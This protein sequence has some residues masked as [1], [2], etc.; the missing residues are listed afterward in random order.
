VRNRS[1]FLKLP[2]AAVV[3]AVA[4]IA[5]AALPAAL[6]SC[7]SSVQK[8]AAQV[9]RLPSGTVMTLTGERTD[10]RQVAA[11]RVTLLSLWATWC[12]ACGEEVAPMNRLAAAVAGRSDALV[13]GVAVGEARAK[14]LAFAT[15][16]GMRY[17][18]WVDDDFRLTDALE[19]RD[20][21]ATLIFGRDGRLVYRGGALDHEALAAFG[22]SLGSA[23]P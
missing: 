11:G 8:P 16:H 18:Q 13:A 1:P 10:V 15:D 5:T 23:Q 14:V 21:P 19:Q 22:R 20:V 6:A 2:R 9:D 4:T 12:A 7:A 17:P 3:A